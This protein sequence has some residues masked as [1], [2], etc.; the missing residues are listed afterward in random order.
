MDHGIEPTC[1]R[2]AKP[3]Q[4]TLRLSCT[5]DNG[6]WSFK[7]YDDGR[8][9]APD[10]IA[11]RAVERGMIDSSVCESMDNQ[12]KS[13]LIFAPGFSTASVITDIS[14]RGYGLSALAA[15]V[16][17]LGGVIKVRSERGSFT[18]FSIEVPFAHSEHH[19]DWSALTDSTQNLP[20]VSR[21][22]DETLPH[23]TPRSR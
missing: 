12:E 16:E 2:G 9:I 6:K 22:R 17:S 15:S 14:G 20:V 3:K 21:K 19:H 1:E 18:E 23:G 4:A 7:V 10:Q 11:K 5:A 13:L 8:G